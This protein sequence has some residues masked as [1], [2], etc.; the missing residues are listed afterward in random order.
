MTYIIKA[1]GKL[2]FFFFLGFLQT[3]MKC[4]LWLKWR[5]FVTAGKLSNSREQQFH[6]WFPR[7]AICCLDT[8]FVSGCAL[9]VG[10]MSNTQHATKKGKC[11]ASIPVVG[12]YMDLVS[13]TFLTLINFFFK[14]TC[15]LYRAWKLL[16]KVS[17]RHLFQKCK[18]S[19][20]HTHVHTLTRSPSTPTRWA[21]HTHM[22][23]NSE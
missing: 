8:S 2:L 19:I 10:L 12:W 17:L 15:R 18:E 6:L 9:N 5:I 11:G 13:L 22:L 4:R 7:A 21:L 3:K 23:G 14:G 16:F 20:S 1:K